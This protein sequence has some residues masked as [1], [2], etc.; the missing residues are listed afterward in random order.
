MN[1]E[2]G[3]VVQGNSASNRGAMSLVSPKMYVMRGGQLQLI[4]DAQEFRKAGY[5]RLA[6]QVI[7]DAEMERLPLA[8]DAQ[9]APSEEIVLDHDTFLGAGHYMTTYG[10]LRKTADGGRI[11]ATTRTRTVT[12]FGGFHG[13]VNMVYSDADGFPVGMSATQRFGVDGTWIGQS[14]RTDYWSEDLSEDSAT[15]TTKIT[16]FHFWQPDRLDDVI[17]RGVDMLKPI[18]EIIADIASI[19][20]QAKSS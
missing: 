15:R 7:S 14:D 2:E 5:D 4:R 13:A 9:L 10:V 17:R 6:V 16:I 20:G 18:V 3:T 1:I 8:V 12:W 19:G 11:D